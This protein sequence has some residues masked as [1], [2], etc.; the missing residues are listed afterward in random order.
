[1]QRRAT[2]A[3]VASSPVDVA[4]LATS[5]SGKQLPH[6]DKIQ[7]SFGRHDISDVKAH[8]GEA[9]RDG[10]S[11]LGAQ[12]FAVGDAVA[13]ASPPDLHTAAHEA[14]HVVQQRA[15]LRPSGGIDTPGD[16][17]E[18]Q[19]DAVANAVV[20]GASAEPI[21][22]QITG[23]KTDAAANDLSVQR[24]S[25][26][27]VINQVVP[28]V[29][30]GD[31]G[32]QATKPHAQLV[33][34]MTASILQSPQHFKQFN[35]TAGQLQHFLMLTQGLIATE[36]AIAILLALPNPAATV[37]ALVLQALI[38]AFL[39]QAAMAAIEEAGQTSTAAMEWWNLC[40]NA[41]GNP[42]QIAKAANAFARLVYHLLQV[43]V[44]GIGVV[45][46]SAAGLRLQQEP[47]APRG[48][49]MD[50][51][52]AK[53]ASEPAE[54]FGAANGPGPVRHRISVRDQTKSGTS[55][56]SIGDCFVAGT[57][58]HT[59]ATLT[60]IEQL[61]IGDLV[62]A[63]SIDGNELEQTTAT[64][65]HIFTRQVGALLDLDFGC[66][67]VT[68]SPEHPF[69]VPGIGWLAA[70]ALEPGVS[71]SNR[72][73]GATVLLG[74][75]RREGRFTVHNIEVDAVHDYFVGSPGL[76]VHNKPMVG[77]ELRSQQLL[78][79]ANALDGGLP[80]RNSLIGEA[81]A[82]VNEVE[83]AGQKSSASIDK[84]VTQ[85]AERVEHAELP[86]AT[87]ELSKRVSAIEARAGQLPQKQ[88]QRWE[89]IAS[90]QRLRTE[91]DRLSADLTAG[92][93]LHELVLQRESIHRDW[94]NLNE[95][96][97]DLEPATRPANA[98]TA[99]WSKRL[100]R[101][102]PSK[103]RKHTKATSDLEAKL[104]STPTASDN[105]PPSQYLPSV[106]VAA[107]EVEALRN[108]E[109]IRGDKTIPGG[110]VHLKYDARRPIGYDRGELV[111]TMRVEITSSDEVHGHPRKF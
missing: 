45:A 101:A 69:H 48:V 15:G 8:D 103:T 47:T 105:A 14:A 51:P 4:K 42:E 79:R 28:G 75:G 108:G 35:M 46:A 98:G 25:G 100:D 55:T 76:L 102:T 92:K 84:R 94:A 78:R 109:L 58:V 32:R 1:M 26:W 93:D 43:I 49:R 30:F 73:G 95:K 91:V 89:M 110:T 80:T 60:P 56:Q 5:G 61:C 19:A 77:N 10:A 74:V 72:L 29:G 90:A 9:A 66:E 12:A 107:L 59:P 111:Q 52:T 21:L 39:L 57:M 13:F 62:F 34:D 44:N 50:S 96:V 27:D 83:A 33:E 20:S 18:Q 54:G 88:Q 6:L 24:I 3:S 40:K 36:A 64:V 16:S 81:R 99:E 106:D 31:M 7:R 17:L 87:A 85:L 71:V 67:I 82:L 22:D 97:S 104:F 23:G 2:G 68:C 65:T 41:K 86:R 38:F 70:G 37:T 53:V 11:K 63:A